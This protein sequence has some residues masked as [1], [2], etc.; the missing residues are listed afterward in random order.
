MQDNCKSFIIFS[1]CAKLEPEVWLH[2]NHIDTKTTA[3]RKNLAVFFQRECSAFIGITKLQ[4]E[5][6][7]RLQIS[8]FSFFHTTKSSKT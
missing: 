2:F 6:K 5:D 3:I 4:A 7:Q 8:S 1:Q